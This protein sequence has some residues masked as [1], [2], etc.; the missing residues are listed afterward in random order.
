MKSTVPVFAD[1]TQKTTQKASLGER[2]ISMIAD[3]KSITQKELALNLSLSVN[4]VKEY[5]TK[6]KKENKLLRIGSD[7]NGYWEVVEDKK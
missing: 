4:T 3:N 7:R 5:I 2:I 6:L 1:A